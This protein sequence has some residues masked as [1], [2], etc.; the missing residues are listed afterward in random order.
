MTCSTLTG[1]VIGAGAYYAG[2]PISV[3]LLSAGFCS[4]AGMLPDIDS[5]SS[6]SFQECIYFAAGLCAVMIVE[7][8]RFFGFDHNAIMLSG[9][10]AFLF[11]RFAIG[12]LVKKL[13]VHRGMFHSIPAAILTGELVFCLSSG[14]FNERIVKSFA[15]VAG[16]LSHLILDEICSIDH[17]GKKIKFKQSFGT[18]LKFYDSKH[19]FTVVILYLLIFFIGAGT[20]RNPDFIANDEQNNSEQNNSEQTVNKNFKKSVRSLLRY[21]AGFDGKH[22]SNNNRNNQKS[23]RRKDIKMSTQTNQSPITTSLP[24]PQLP[25]PST[26]T[27]TSASIVPLPPELLQPPVNVANQNSDNQFLMQYRNRRN[28]Q[29][30]NSLS[31]KQSEV[32]TSDTAIFVSDVLPVV[33]SSENNNIPVTNYIDNENETAT[34]EIIDRN[35]HIRPKSISPNHLPAPLN[36]L[37]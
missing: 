36:R 4:M 37:N 23:A 7:R 3:G 26:S 12:G 5:S 33:I 30:T 18:A 15:I 28:Q 21:L 17:T 32:V 20:I 34:L 13:T 24:Q 9:A 10:I 27:T 2:F 6:R 1:V 14:D 16:Y 31:T 25:Q 8:M 19:I 35:I 11:V 22:Y 29:P